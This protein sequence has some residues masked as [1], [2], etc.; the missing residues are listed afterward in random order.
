MALKLIDSAIMHT[1]TV[2]ELY[3]TK[4]RIFKVDRHLRL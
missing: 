4:A 2:I 3:T 1:P